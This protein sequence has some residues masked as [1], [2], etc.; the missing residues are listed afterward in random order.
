[1]KSRNS[2]GLPLEAGAIK[3]VL[4]KAPGHK[5]YHLEDGDYDLTNAI[6]F[7]CD[8]GTPVR[9]A[10]EGWVA[11]VVTG[12]TKNYSG[13]EEPP[14]SVMPTSEQDG[15]Y[16]VLEHSN[17]E[18]TMYS[19]LSRVEVVRGML[20]KEGQLLGYSGNTGWSIEPHLHFVVFR[21]YSRGKLRLRSLEPR[22]KRN[23]SLPQE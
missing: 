21:L 17:G 11:D 13:R 10:R 3:K 12:V 16:V 5:V 19:H 15:N 18:Y 22:W 20:V 7:L 6:D 8:E 1:M 2:Y 9:A 23:V 4:R 14:E